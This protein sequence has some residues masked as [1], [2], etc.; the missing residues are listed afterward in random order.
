MRWC[1]YKMLCDY[2]LVFTMLDR[3]LERVVVDDS[4]VHDETNHIIKGKA[5][6]LR[7]DILIVEQRAE[8]GPD[9]AA[10]GKGKPHESE[11]GGRGTVRWDLRNVKLSTPLVD[12]LDLGR[13]HV[14][15]KLFPSVG[16]RHSGILL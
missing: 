15:K 11:F 14:S 6:L 7:S 2:G 13:K 10:A 1:S 9:E 12:L 4:I 8:A 3:L 5:F 16:L